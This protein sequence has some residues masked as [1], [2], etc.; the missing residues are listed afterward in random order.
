MSRA[1]ITLTTDFGVGSP[2]VAQM[3]GVILSLNAEA[4]IVDLAHTIPPQDIRQGARVL[5][6]A[7]RTFPAETIH[8]CVVDPGVGTE[9][10]IV[11]VKIRQQH[12]V[13][14]DNGVISLLVKEN[15]PEQLITLSN[16]EY[17]LTDVSATFHGRDI[18]APAAAYLSLGLD[19]AS[20]GEPA[21]DVTKITW[22]EVHAHDREIHGMVVSFD[23]FGNLITDISGGMLEEAGSS[24]SLQIKCGAHVVREM[25]RAYGRGVAGSLVALVGSSGLLEL[26]VVNGSAAQMLGV[27]VGDE[28]TVTW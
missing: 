7:T 1:I 15:E 26:A 6:E 4:N 5:H 28:V 18:M 17:W 13:C 24:S 20:L 27:E 3:K 10:E 14:P 25:V 16:P 11:Y 22:A 8:I 12:F 23:T 21:K 19:P 2:Y 9:R